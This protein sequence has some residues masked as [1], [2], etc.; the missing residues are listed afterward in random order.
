[1]VKLKENVKRDKQ[2]ELM[3]NEGIVSRTGMQCR[4]KT[5]EVLVH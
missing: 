1:V 4:I 3:A 5:L 2:W